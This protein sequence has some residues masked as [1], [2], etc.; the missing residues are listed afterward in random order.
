LS[1]VS[2]RVAPP[3]L[4]LA[5]LLLAGCADLETSRL[6]PALASRLERET[7]RLRAANLTFRYTHDAGTRDAGWEDRRASIVV[8]DSSV[9]I[10]KNAKIGLEITPASRRAYEVSRE[11]DRVRI[12]AGT[13]KSRESWSF[14]PPDSAPAWTEAIR[15][16]IRRSNSVANE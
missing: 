4:L 3:R 13:G 8:T 11:K 7:I 5:A 10:H 14:V 16:V 12:G 2:H 15:Q 6:E 9:L 1:R